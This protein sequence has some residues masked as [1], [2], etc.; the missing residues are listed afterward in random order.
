MGDRDAARLTDHLREQRRLVEAPR[1][2]PTPMQ[3]HRDDGAGLGEE[4]PAGIRH[5]A[6]HGRRKVEPVTVFEGV[7]ELARN[8][9]IAH[10]RPR[11]PVGWRSGD[12]LHRQH[13]GAGIVGERDPQPLAIGRR[14]ERKLRPACRAQALAADRLAAGRAQLRQRHIDGEAERGPQHA[15][16]PS[17]AAWSSI[18]GEVPVH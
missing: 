14:D 8:I 18:S 3:R 16:N 15:G 9:V 6:P 13:A 10:R 2:L 5:P 7:N 12:R 4:R 1:P 17:E 11:A